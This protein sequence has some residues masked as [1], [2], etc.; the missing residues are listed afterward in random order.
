MP[1]EKKDGFC[2]EV[3]PSLAMETHQKKTQTRDLFNWDL[4]RGVLECSWKL[5]CLDPWDDG[6]CYI[7]T[8]VALSKNQPSITM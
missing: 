8:F 5:L 1:F 6:I 3:F 4:S 2:G 7:F